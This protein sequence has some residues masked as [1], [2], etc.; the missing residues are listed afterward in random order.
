MT[1][2]R[3][4]ATLISRRTTMIDALGRAEAF[5]QTY[6]EQRDQAQVPIRLEYLNSMWA[7]LEEVQAQLED[8]EEAEEDRSCHELASAA[9]HVRRPQ[10]SS[11]ADTGAL[12]YWNIDIRPA[13]PRLSAATTLHPWNVSE[14][15]VT[16]TTLLE[17]LAKGISAGIGS[18]YEICGPQQ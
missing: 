14:L 8:S 4:H 12:P 16:R 15:A 6:D 2:P 11:S 5:I 17:P 18:R 9:A 10:R 3:Q 13:R 1:L 7:T